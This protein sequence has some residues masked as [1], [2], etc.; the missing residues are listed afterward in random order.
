MNLSIFSRIIDES[1]PWLV[2]Q[3]RYKEANLTMRKAGKL[4]GIEVPEKFF[5]EERE[6]G[7]MV[8]A[9]HT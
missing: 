8:A 4:N 9:K 6:V 1:I 7:N 2:S 3:G 5:N